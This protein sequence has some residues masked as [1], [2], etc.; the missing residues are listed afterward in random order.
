MLTTRGGNLSSPAL[1]EAAQ[2]TRARLVVLLTD[3]CS[4][5]F[6]AVTATGASPVASF[7]A[8]PAVQVGYETS[9]ILS[10]L[11]LD[12]EGIVHVNG[13]TWR[14]ATAS[15]EFG[16]NNDADGALFTSALTRTLME[17]RFEQLDANRDGVVSWSEL[18]GPVTDLSRSLFDSYKD[19]YLSRHFPID[20]VNLDRLR[21][22]GRRRRSSSVRLV[23]RSLS[24]ERGSTVG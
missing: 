11:F 7:A 16:W 17:S 20:S 23:D 6:S 5:G 19:G 4:T 2:R 22:Q 3:A 15:G 18:Q 8:P 10:S 24:G 12:H 21:G 9:R 1:I 14:T 13:S